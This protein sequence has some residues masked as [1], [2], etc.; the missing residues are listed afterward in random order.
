VSTSLAALVFLLRVMVPAV[1]FQSTPVD[2]TRADVDR[3]AG[4]LR[5]TRKTQS[6]SWKT[7]VGVEAQRGKLKAVHACVQ[8]LRDQG[9]DP[10]KRVF[11][12]WSI[13]RSRQ[14]FPPQDDLKGRLISRSFQGYHL[15]VP[16][17]YDPR[18]AWPLVICLHP[19]DSMNG[20]AYIEALWSRPDLRESAIVFAPDW[21]GKG[22][23]RWSDRRYLKSLIYDMVGDPI[24]QEFN[25]DRNRI[26]LDG[27]GEGGTEAWKVASSFA[28]HFAGL[29]IRGGP[30]PPVQA[31]ADGAA[32]KPRF[33]YRDLGN[34]NV[35]FFYMLH[36]WPESE[37]YGAFKIAIQGTTR[38]NVFHED[39]DPHLDVTTLHMA[40]DAM[41]GPVLHF[42]KWKWRNPYPRSIDWSVKDPR[43]RRS[44]WVKSLD[45][46]DSLDKSDLPNFQAY[47][48][49][50]RNLVEIT[51]HR[52]RG[53]EVNLNDVLLDLDRPV[54]LTVN[55]R[56]LFHGQPSRSL[57]RLLRA[58]DRSGD[59]SDVYP[60]SVRIDVPPLD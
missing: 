37:D 48:D 26:F 45:E 6:P 32:G 13:L 4:L 39:L 29:I 7:V 49:R 57:A 30:P 9:R 58:V 17:S 10:M 16:A 19:A 3:L 15:Q 53:L 28:Y 21:P 25:I 2:M 55:R 46:E 38:Y 24:F 18:R 41:A 56:I 33:R 54:T 12:W 59:W 44:Y 23:P 42:L 5:E 14:A 60:W 47:L 31:Q 51:S 36:M 1:L 8:D 27:A 40:A 20:R 11:G 43:T 22:R 52:I 35:L 34:L 50:E